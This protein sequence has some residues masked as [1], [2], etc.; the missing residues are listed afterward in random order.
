[1]NDL[2]EFGSSEK[3]MSTLD[4]AEITG[5]KHA[6]VMRDVRNIIS[7]INQSTSGLVIPD[8]IK[9]DYHRGDRTQYKH[10]SEKSQNIIFDFCFG[11]TGTNYIVE[12]SYYKD[13]KGEERKMYVLNKK[14]CLL[15]S[16]GYDV[17]LRA[18]IIDR[19]EYLEKKA[20]ANVISLPNFEDPAEAAMEKN[21]TLLK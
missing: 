11:N 17:S 12:E 20:R 18:K 7:Q 5:K 14:A 13:A 1:M 15:L 9:D 8:D 21:L 10:L 19:W 6:H 2:I 16:S 3:M 4:I